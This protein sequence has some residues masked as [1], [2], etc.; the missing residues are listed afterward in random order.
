MFKISSPIGP[1]DVEVC[2]TGVHWIKLAPEVSNDNFSKYTAKI[3]Q[4]RIIEML[5]EKSHHMIDQVLNWFQ[6][7]F[8][9]SQ[10]IDIDLCP[11]IVSEEGNFRQKVWLTLKQE[12]GFGQTITY[13]SLAKLCKNPKAFQ[14]VGSAM[15]NNPISLVVPCH[16]VIKSDGSAGNYSKATKND[17]KEWL[18]HFESKK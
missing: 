7:Y 5:S 4:I 10:V 16:R 11:K 17:I 3:Q 18:L 14:A 2:E 12:I 1:Y 13:G 6:S 9:K 15:S 8:T